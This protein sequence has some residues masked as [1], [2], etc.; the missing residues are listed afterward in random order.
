[1][2]TNR[3]KVGNKKKPKINPEVMDK[4]FGMNLKNRKQ[5]INKVL[6]IYF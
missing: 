1:M 4:N 2:D 3:S 6:D 5:E